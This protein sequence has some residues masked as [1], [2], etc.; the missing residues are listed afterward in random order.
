M[1]ETVEMVTPAGLQKVPLTEL[2]MRKREGWTIWEAPKKGKTFYVD[3]R[4]GGD[5]EFPEATAKKTVDR[6][7]DTEVL[8][9]E[10]K[11]GKKGRS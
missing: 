4:T 6:E 3:P 2:S 5:E 10:K 1:I 7:A 9:S 8:P 11:K